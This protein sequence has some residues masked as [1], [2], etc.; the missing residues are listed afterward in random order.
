[1]ASKESSSTSASDVKGLE[2]T[3]SFVFEIDLNEIP[4]SPSSDNVCSPV[5]EAYQAV[6]NCL[7]SPKQAAGP[8]AELP[9]ESRNGSC[10]CGRVEARGG[11][12][13][14]DGCERWFHISCAGMRARQ[15]VVLED[16]TCGGCLK[17][18][19][20]S[21]R[22]PLGFVGS[23]SN[24]AKGNGVR[25]LDINALPPSD[26]FEGEA[27]EESQQQRMYASDE[28]ISRSSFVYPNSWNGFELQR[29]SSLIKEPVISG[30]EG[31]MQHKL[32]MSRSFEEADL[33]S[34]LGGMLRSNN[35]NTKLRRKELARLSRT[36]S[37]AEKQE[38]YR[39]RR[40][41][42][43]EL[44]MEP[45]ICTVAHRTK[46]VEVGAEGNGDSGSQQI[47]DA[48]PVQ[49]EDFFV[50][51][52]GGI[53]PRPS[54]HICTQIWPVGYQSSWHDKITGSIFTCDILDGGDAGP[55]FKVTR[56]SCSMFLISK[57]STI[58]SRR[59]S[60]R[61]ET[62]S[63]LERK[64]FATSDIG[65][66]EDDAIQMYLSE[67]DPQEQ[68]LLSCLG[69]DLNKAHKDDGFSLQ[70]SFLSGRTA[71][72]LPGNID[73]RDEI[74]EFCVEGRSSA[75][76]WEKVSEKLICACREVFKKSSA[77][78]FYCKHGLNKLVS[79]LVEDDTDVNQGP[80][81]RFC[82]SFGP[83]NI[84]DLIQSVNE[85]D[86]SCEALS[87]WLSKDRFGLDVEFVQEL[88]ELL[89]G[90]HSCMGYE[91]LNKR[92]Q[93]PTSQTAGSGLLLTKRKSDVQG[94]VDMASDILFKGFKR[95]RK[96]NFF[97]S[98]EIDVRC[99]PPGKPLSTK[100]SAELVGD[101]LQVWEFLW[102][103]RE[104]LGMK[105]SILFEQLE[106]ELINPWSDGPNFLEKFEKE[107]QENKS[108][109]AHEKSATMDLSIPPREL[110]TAGSGDRHSTFIETGSAKEAS[111]AR[112]ASRTYHKCTGVSLTKVHS[113][114]L[115]VLVG[116]LQAKVA[117]LVDPNFDF[118]ESKA[119]RGRKKDVESSVPLNKSKIDM[120]PVN[121]FTWP[122]LA[123]RYILSVLS[124]DFNLESPE[125]TSREGVKVFRCLQGDGGVLCGSLSGVAGMEADALLL[126][127]ATKQICGSLKRENEI[128][129]VVEDK[130]VEANDASDLVCANDGG[131]PEW[132]DVLEPVRKLPTNVGTR[133]RKCVYEALDRNPPEWARKILEHSISKE[134]YKGNASGP[135]KKAVLSVLAD[136]KNAGPQQ[137]PEK[138]KK[139]KSV[140]NI[141]DVVT[142]QCRSVLRRT[143][144]ADESR[145]F[146]N[147]LG[148][149]SL[150]L[151]DN[152]DEGVLGSPAMVSRPLD[153]RTIDLRL[154]V[155]YYNGSH[156]AFLEDVRE[157]WHNIRTAYVDRP[158]LIQLAESLSQ[159]FE[160]L[161]ETEVL[162]LVQKC[163][164]HANP[165]SSSS[166]LKEE[167]SELLKS[168]SDIPKA[169]WDEGVCKVCGI[170]RDDESVLLC[171]TCDSEYHTYCLVPP[172]GKIP[173]GNWYCPSCVSG[174]GKA[175][176]SSRRTKV[177]TRRRQKRYQGEGSRAFFEA[178]NRLAVT[179]GEKEYWEFSIE[180]RVYLLKF[181]CDEVLNSVILREHLDQ[182]A[183]MLSDLQQKLR[184]LSMELK[185]L[186]FREET[187]TAR[188][189]K[190]NMITFDGGVEAGREKMTPVLANHGG[191]IG[192][193]PTLINKY[194][195]HMSP[196][197]NLVQIQGL[198][199]ENKHLYSFSSKVMS[200]Q[201]CN[202]NRP[203]IAVV[204]TETSENASI[205]DDNPIPE[206]HSS[207]AS[208]LR[209]QEPN[210]DVEQSLSAKEKIMDGIHSLLNNKKGFDAGNNGQVLSQGFPPSVDARQAENG[211]VAPTKI[212]DLFVGYYSNTKID[213]S[214]SETANAELNSVKNEISVL[215][216][217]IA[218]IESQILNVSSRR[219]F[220]GRDSAG[221]L[222]WV[223]G[224]PD[225]RPWLVVDGCV[226]LQPKRK[227]N[228][229]NESFGES[230]G[231]RVFPSC[232]FY[233]SDD[234]IHELIK[235]L[236]DSDPREKDLRESI[237]QFLKLRPLHSN[238][239]S[240][241]N[242]D[243]SNSQAKLSNDGAMTVPR[244]LFT[245]AFAILE[246]NY[247]P[248]LEPEADEEPPK[249]RGK[250]TKVIY[251]DR[252][253]R[254]DC[255]EPIWPSRQH[256]LSCHHTFCTS[257]EFEG[258]NDG[259][260]NSGS[261]APDES[262]EH[263]KG[264][265]TMISE[266]TKEVETKVLKSSEKFDVS[267]RLI[268][269]QKEEMTCPFTLEEISKKFITN[270]SNKELAKQIG[271]LGSNGAPSFVPTSSPY[272]H[273]PTL[274]LDPSQRSSV[275][276]TPIEMDFGK[277]EAS[278][279]RESLGG[280]ELSKTERLMAVGGFPEL[281]GVDSG[282]VPM[283]AL[284]PLVGKA[285]EILRRLKINLL[286]IDATLPD[287]AF[288]PTKAHSSNRC[289]WR[290]FLK[291][292][293]SI[294][295]MVKAVIVF[296]DMIKTEYL[297]SGWWYWS[298]L[299]AAA[300]TST[301]SSLALRIYALDAAIIYD[302]TPPGLEHQ[303]V[304]DTTPKSSGKK[305]KGS[306]S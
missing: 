14:C 115:N 208:S 58:L 38:I 296:E 258:H 126:A 257:L 36:N 289:C 134:V 210:G 228:Q 220:V 56:F 128:W 211:T 295:E 85:L 13:V 132:A 185:N 26:D 39:S 181:L 100:F 196:T 143:V 194:D 140:S 159:N 260:C 66:K 81:T 290:A 178:L 160:S 243:S 263:P 12:L 125:I 286:D 50:L 304:A 80:L 278:N 43:S 298:S 41:G 117:P 150:D 293:D 130:D 237:L 204:G 32:S 154:A 21:K 110:D 276:P 170:D 120:L 199:E 35:A 158:E 20:G 280:K 283:S 217:S 64:S 107:I 61:L 255:L 264:K 33:S 266:A 182:C 144:A 301:M 213:F 245:K 24:S 191:C 105:D 16:W 102:R 139:E 97:Q 223:L 175:H 62:N 4:S 149:T 27:S 111:T 129:A 69:N 292:A 91:I 74:G 221:R 30:F 3:R 135:T 25:L 46:T 7:G 48:L 8:P 127:E 254:C 216:E 193:Q 71:E 201:H 68:D 65:Y 251:E 162:T 239:Q 306:D 119:K 299:S 67:P 207:H 113:S 153:F 54:Y 300:R 236:R 252:M 78:H 172:L 184:S 152:D 51:R 148:T 47:N 59:T 34:N 219:E 195:Y 186:K 92:R 55:V 176:D 267:S 242:V 18:G 40:G 93:Y 45:G 15:A 6:R 167:L 291:S 151:Y 72:V 118:G 165:E 52:L 82:S 214:M 88:I 269:F 302:K 206:N 84:P 19:G 303:N 174:Q 265:A 169:P 203:D 284:R 171:D 240:E 248:C 177:V 231:S 164:E 305:R 142:K 141:T 275:V 225:T 60:C 272:L 187:L 244:S 137:K 79:G 205:T 256:C 57:G 101:I 1:M 262:E 200:G 192:Q 49:Y 116:E 90:A 279:T 179:M 259:K 190:D 250:K 215:S 104:I 77:L 31:V 230:S 249:K 95:P 44:S 288:R 274:V 229:Q 70:S 42:F 109:T 166:I 53:D 86:T 106:E 37:S 282:I 76:V 270:D 161:Y 99:S 96:Y 17:E 168:A 155:G 173:E 285:C 227:E 11:V 2:N 123:R 73:S 103:F 94:V 5:R 209:R 121:E 297:R 145:T 83:I 114:L 202:G 112:L 273:D 271:L 180:E 147:L 89:P 238:Q 157:V 197:G 189:T 163:K 281:D 234:E 247:G 146:C 261:S 23:T 232:V 131:I 138:K 156:E 246:K 224:R 28:N 124:M 183:D 277:S 87:K 212:G 222:Y 75:L 108:F 294:I 10:V 287:E 98:H 9:T 133:I 22:W 122:E 63:S 253:Y 235:W 136:V 233:K 226:S 29:G 198:P 268:K 241:N 218:S 188:S